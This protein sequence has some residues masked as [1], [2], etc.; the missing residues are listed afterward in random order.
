[1][2]DKKQ[3]KAARTFAAEWA[4]KGGE[5]QDARRFW[6]GFLIKVPGTDKGGLLS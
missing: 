6:T 4:G 3:K 2:T 5:R 1:M